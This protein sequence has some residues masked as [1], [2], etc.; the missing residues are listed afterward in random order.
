M[1]TRHRID[2][3]LSSQRMGDVERYFEDITTIIERNSGVNDFKLVTADCSNVNAPFK[4]DQ[5]S[6]FKLTDPSMDIVDISKG[7]I[8]MKVDID[9]Q[10][11]F[12]N[13][14]STTDSEMRDKTVFFVGFKSG[15]M[16]INNYTIF[17]NGRM[18]A[19][20]NTKSKQEQT[21]VYNCKSRDEKLNRPGLYSPHS[22][23]QAMD[24]CVCGTYVVLPPFSD[25]NTAQTIS[26]EVVIQHDDILSLSSA[27]YFPRFINKDLELQLSCNLVQNMVF[28]HIPITSVAERTG[29]QI[30][31]SMMVPMSSDYRFH[32]CGDYAKCM[33]GYTNN[34]DKLQSSYVTIVPTNLNVIEAKSYIYGFNIKETTKQNIIETFSKNNFILPAQFITHYT[35]SQLPTSRN[36]SANIQVP[37]NNACQLIFTFPTTGNQLTVSRNPH[38]ESVQCHVSDRVIPDKYFTTLDK[39]HAEMTLASLNLDSLFTASNELIESLTKDRKEFGTYSL[40]KVDDSDYMLVLNL[41]RFGNGCFSDGMTGD[42]IPININANYMYGDS[43]PHYYTDEDGA[44]KLSVQNINM[45]VVEDAYWIFGPDGGEFYLNL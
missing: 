32:Q 27:S 15:A 10:F 42:H 38:L 24:D 17:S 41:E 23:V 35:L 12:K 11:L 36:I 18:T 34:T 7:F 1:A 14:E 31:A 44:K 22:H 13:L 30:D 26:F 37:M 25:K 8:T 4:A 9:V 45:F 21:I 19:C 29:A 3:A 33:I 6:M 40:K 43:N 20:K 2:E 28:C 5:F 39:T 16:I